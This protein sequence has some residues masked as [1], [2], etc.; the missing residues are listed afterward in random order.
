MNS[1][2]TTSRR[3]F[4]IG[5]IVDHEGA[6]SIGTGARVFY[7]LGGSSGLAEDFRASFGDAQPGDIGKRVYRV[8]GG[9]LQ[10]ENNEQRAARIDR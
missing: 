5:E 3:P 4:L 10:M 7:P 1:S 8:A 6:L 2:T 9:H